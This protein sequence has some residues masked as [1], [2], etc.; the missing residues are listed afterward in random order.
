[1]HTISTWGS[2]K[3]LRLQRLAIA[4]LLIAAITVHTRILANFQS[5]LWR[6]EAAHAYLSI[7]VVP[8]ETHDVVSDAPFY[9]SA[10]L[11]SKDDNKV[12]VWDAGSAVFQHPV[13]KKQEKLTWCADPPRMACLSLRSLA[14]ASTHHRN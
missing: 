7:P 9:F 12:T 4:L 8:I 11:L 2:C 3:S 13:R 10:C 5:E 6:R 1:M 14:P